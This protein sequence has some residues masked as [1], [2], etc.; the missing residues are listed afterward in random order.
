MASSL[1]KNLI[2][3]MREPQTLQATHSP[4]NSD[5]NMRDFS[6]SNNENR[7]EQTQNDTDFKPR[8]LKKNSAN[9]KYYQTIFAERSDISLIAI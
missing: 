5:V 8:S 9:I 6:P 7:K 3:D 2:G 4:R 1:E